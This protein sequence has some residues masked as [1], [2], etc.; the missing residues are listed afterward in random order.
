MSLDKLSIFFCASSIFVNLSKT[1][2]NVLLLFSKLISNL[3]FTLSL[4]SLKRSS[5]LSFVLLKSSFI[6]CV[7]SVLNSPISLTISVS[8]LPIRS[9][10]DSLFLFFTNKIINNIIVN[11]NKPKIIYSILSSPK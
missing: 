3:S 1:A 2:V 6:L 5:N 10:T 7:K 8:I 9:T 11:T 4:I